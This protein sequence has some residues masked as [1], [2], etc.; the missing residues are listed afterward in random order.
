MIQHPGSTLGPGVYCSEPGTFTISAAGKLT[1]D[2][3]NNPHAQWVFQTT[4]TVVTAASTSIVLKNG[5]QA[6]N[7]FW[8]VGNLTKLIIT[9]LCLS[10][11]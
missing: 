6:K 7:V 9:F 1:L 11:S 3:E 4:T 5:A 8:S 2:G 10:R